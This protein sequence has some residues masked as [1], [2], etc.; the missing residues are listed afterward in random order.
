MFVDLS[1]YILEKSNRRNLEN[2]LITKFI[3]KHR[4]IEKKHLLHEI[5]SF[6][7]S[8]Q[9]KLPNSYTQ[10][11]DRRNEFLWEEKF[12]VALKKLN[13]D[14]VISLL[15]SSKNLYKLNESINLE[16]L[17][18]EKLIKLCDA[19]IIDS[20]KINSPEQIKE[21]ELDCSL[22]EVISE[23]AEQKI[24]EN[25]T[26]I[27]SSDIEKIEDAINADFTKEVNFEENVELYVDWKE[28]DPPTYR[29]KMASMIE[30]C[31]LDLRKFLRSVLANDGD[32]IK[33]KVPIQIRD[34]VN[35]LM[36]EKEKKAKQ[37]GDEITLD[38]VD[39]FL[40]S[41]DFGTLISIILHNTKDFS[42][43]LK[44]PDLNQFKPF[45]L[46][47]QNIRNPR[48]HADQTLPVDE[49][50]YNEAKYLISWVLKRIQVYFKEN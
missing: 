32:W 2:L 28:G 38:H 16:N 11:S 3:L 42:K 35:P 23:L 14:E 25:K 30:H 8:N 31:E 34:R 10:S 33:S 9:N 18:H 40:N 15:N 1:S 7:K 27:S 4:E 21:L 36:I 44:D 6:L 41:T 5:K 48:S 43:V 26:D 17:Q 20:L 24:Q 46:G 45:L 37:R 49:N 39:S 47:V 22:A 13:N 12:D 50:T 19:G 29:M